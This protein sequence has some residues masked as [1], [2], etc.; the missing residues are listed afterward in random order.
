M[1]HIIILLLA[2]FLLGACSSSQELTYR[3]VNNNDLWSVRIEKG[4]ISG[5]FEIYINDELILEETPSMFGDNIDEKIIYKNH[6][7]R[8]IVNKISN[9]WGVES[10]KLTLLIDNELITQMDF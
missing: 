1:K 3:P 10:Q 7:V 5:Q 2:I 4:T 9:F 6:S 8:L